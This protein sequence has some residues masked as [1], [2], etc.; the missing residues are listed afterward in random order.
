[1]ILEEPRAVQEALDEVTD[2]DGKQFFDSNSPLVRDELLTT[3]ERRVRGHPV[4]SKP[5]LARKTK[6]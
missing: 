1:M 6:R 5:E 4:R 3:V 2:E